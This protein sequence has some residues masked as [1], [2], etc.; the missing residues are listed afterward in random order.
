MPP[1]VSPGFPVSDIVIAIALLLPSL[2]LIREQNWRI[3]LALTTFML[4][5]MSISFFV[6][7]FGPF[8]CANSGGMTDDYDA[9]GF[10]MILV[11]ALTLIIDY[12]ILF[13]YGIVRGSGWIR[14]KSLKQ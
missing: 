7:A 3:C 1:Q 13:L 6:S 2:L 12:L 4:L 10:C 9:P 5:V 14:H 8:G 11:Y